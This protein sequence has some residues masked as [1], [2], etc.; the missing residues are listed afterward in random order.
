[1]KIEKDDPRLTAYV[2][3]EL[4]PK[5]AKLMEHA[6][7]ADPALQ[8]VLDEIERGQAIL[9]KSLGTEDEK[10][11]PRQRAAIMRAA[12]EACGRG[13][14]EP[15]SSHPKA[16]FNLWSWPLAAAAVVVASLV[17]VTLFPGP[18]AG[19]ANGRAATGTNPSVSEQ[20]VAVEQS[21]NTGKAIG[22]PLVA[23]NKSLP[24]ITR[25]IRESRGLPSKEE[26][27]IEELLNAFPL[28]AN[29]TVTESNGCSLGV[30]VIPCPWS[31]SGSLVFIK[32]RG[33]KNRDARISLEYR[34]DEA[35]VV[36]S[37]LMGYEL[38]ENHRV[39]RAMPQN[40]AAGS[41][42][43]LAMWV[44]SKNQNLGKLA[45]IVDEAA[46]SEM[47]LIRNEETEASKDGRFASLICC[48]GLWL[49]EERSEMIDDALVLGLARQ[50]AADSLVPDRYDFL[51]LVDQAVRARNKP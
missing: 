47:T 36:S 19:N 16:G 18:D 7:A 1:M 51:E 22:L 11:L 24:Q 40:M 37:R 8:L 25:S 10:L 9:C 32:I 39:R 2:L 30:E 21:G 13:K 42:V 44:E 34:I 43:F 46:A 50:V 41:E 33:A 4:T 20:F 14:I 17:I 3:G 6:I 49:R 38:E 45:W 48:F 35:S 26:V 27:R 5:E 28:D 12:G 31:P 29:A 23:G 15:L